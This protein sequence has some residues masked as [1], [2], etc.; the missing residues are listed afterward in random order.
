LQRKIQ[1]IRYG[2]CNPIMVE[3]K[4]L[5]NDEIQDKNKRHEYKKKFIKYKN[6][7]NACLSVFWCLMF[8][9]IEATQQNSRI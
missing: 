6:A 7:T 8:I 9:K 5:H 4:L 3:L 2:F 1:I